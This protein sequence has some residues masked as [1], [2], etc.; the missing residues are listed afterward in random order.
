MP[1]LILSNG[2]KRILEQLAAN[3]RAYIQVSGF[4]HV[5]TITI[6]GG[7][8]T[9]DRTNLQTLNAMQR[10]GLV[11]S[12][13]VNPRLHRYYITEDGKKAVQG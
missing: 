8:S 12:V 1:H 10:G 2:I 13:E 6:I 3:P 11:R 5:K 9:D 4:G 7:N